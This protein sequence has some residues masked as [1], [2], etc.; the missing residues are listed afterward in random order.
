MRSLSV[1]IVHVPEIRKA[2]GWRYQIGATSQR[3]D[4]N[5]TFSGRWQ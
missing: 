1:S 4:V 2:L 5:V 3:H